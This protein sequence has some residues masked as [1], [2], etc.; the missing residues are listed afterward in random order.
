MIATNAA[1]RFYTAGCHETSTFPS[2]FTSGTSDSFVYSV[3][4]TNPTTVSCGGR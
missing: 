4:I 2:K 1:P 3:G